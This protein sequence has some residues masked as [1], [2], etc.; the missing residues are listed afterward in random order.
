MS[1]PTLEPF[2]VQQRWQ[3]AAPQSGSW[4]QN[5][6]SKYIAR[7]AS[8]CASHEAGPEREPLIGHI[9]L[10]A[11]FPD[12]GYLRI[13]AVSPVH[14]VTCTGHVPDGL[15]ELSL[16]LNVLVYGLRRNVLQKLT[17]DVAAELAATCA[18]NI[19]TDFVDAIQTP[20]SAPGNSSH[21]HDA[22]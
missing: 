13:S 11:L 4:W 17:D 15:T 5:L 10:L 3:L 7:L 2:A 18:C 12:H 16:T 19:T 20:S 14:P 22:E 8:A 21:R 6:L 9:K 1:E